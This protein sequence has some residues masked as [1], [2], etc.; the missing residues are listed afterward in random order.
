MKKIHLKL[1]FDTV[2]GNAIF[3]MRSVIDA[4][5]KNGRYALIEDYLNSSIVFGS[6]ED[7]LRISREFADI[8]VV[9]VDSSTSTIKAA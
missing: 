4:L 2:T 3:V 8:E 7:L 1:G 9:V 5:Y 6:L